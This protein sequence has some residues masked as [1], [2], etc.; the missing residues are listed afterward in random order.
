MIADKPTTCGSQ[1]NQLMSQ[2]DEH[3]EAPDAPNDDPNDNS[4][5][6]NAEQHNE[7]TCES[8]KLTGRNE[9]VPFE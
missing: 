3:D 2:C 7:V 5:Y 9:E 4:V 8:T 1:V 6:T